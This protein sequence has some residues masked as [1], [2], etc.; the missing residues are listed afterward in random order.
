MLRGASASRNQREWTEATTPST[1]TV[2]D[3]VSGSYSPRASTVDT[4]VTT[5]LDRPAVWGGGCRSALG[6]AHQVTWCGIQMLCISSGV[7]GSYRP[8]GQHRRHARHHSA[9]QACRG[10]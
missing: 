6:H 4:P 2:P 5:A 9:R 1:T 7:S 3:G 8:A 10:A